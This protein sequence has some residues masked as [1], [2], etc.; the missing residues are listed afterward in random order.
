[1]S[2]QK[3]KVG[4]GIVMAVIFVLAG[5][6][7]LLDAKAAQGNSISDLIVAY[8]SAVDD[9]VL[10]VQSEYSVINQKA[11][12]QVKVSG[13]NSLSS[14]MYVSGSVDSVKSSA[15][16]KAKTIGSSKEFTV[17]KQGDYSIL[18]IDSK[19]NAKITQTSVVMEM[20]AVWIYYNEMNK[21][22]ASEKK[23]KKF[24]DKTYSTCKKN[25]MNTVIFQV[26]PCA[27]AMY[28]SDYFPWSVY[29]T[30]TAG[31][32]PG[33]D[34][35]AYAVKAAHKKGLSIQAWIN[36]YRI[37]LS[38][39]KLSSLPKDSIARKWASSSSKAKR[40]NVLTVN[41]ALYFN[42]AS[43]D[44]QNLVAKGVTE[45]VKKYDVDGIHMDDYF[46]PSLGVANYK[47]FDYTEYKAY[48][49][50]CKKAGKSP[51]SLVSWRRSNVNAMVK[52]V[53]AAVKAVD[54]DCLFGISPAGNLTN[55]YSKTAYYSDV[56]KWMKGTGYIDYICP[57]IYWS[58]TQKTAPYKQV[59]KQWTEIPRSHSVNLYIGLAG[60]RAGIS[61]KEAAALYDVG[62]S[63]SS[64]ILK[65]QVRYARS[66]KKVD[67]FF[68]FSYGTY[69]NS[70]AKKE[71]KNLKKELAKR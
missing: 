57:Q 11:T 33:F 25:N 61:K 48:T 40:R 54:S 64:T 56:K 39:T 37:T 63:K 6:I 26:R 10:K 38:T 35:F 13:K 21:K 17:D 27:D 55:L 47:K 24:I 7:I 16:N 18:A 19:G 8:G 36:P 2:L 60:Y 69:E 67:G 15:W 20:K 1:M 49:R 43:K 51:A 9:D 66:T 71:V 70:A 52:K 46:Y 34:P 59:V 14:L 68:L 42:P 12:V 41:G 62:W 3:W 28:S 65:R 45:I 23:W 22:A 32:N 53:Y 29:A 31:K 44:V 4:A 58:F 5:R 50:K 30:G